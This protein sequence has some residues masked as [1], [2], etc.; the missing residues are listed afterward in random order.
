MKSLPSRD[1]SVIFDDMYRLT[2]QMA[3]QRHNPDFL[4]ESVGKRQALMDEYDALA[5]EYPAEKTAFEQGPA[6]RD[7]VEKML[8]M[9][10]A[11]IKALEEHKAT[12]HKDVA[13]ANAQQKVL[14]YLNKAQPSG[15]SLMDYK[16]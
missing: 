16:Q 1:F 15:G 8:S 12:A 11:I 5:L 7:Q 10:S 14:D 6:A 9:D 13:S 2:N 4:L 3:E